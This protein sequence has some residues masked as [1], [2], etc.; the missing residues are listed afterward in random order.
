MSLLLIILTVLTAHMRRLNL[1]EEMKPVT[2]TLKEFHDPVTVA[3]VKE[4][5]MPL[6]P[7]RCLIID[8]KHILLLADDH[9]IHHSMDV[10]LDYM[11]V[12]FLI[13]LAERELRPHIK[14]HLGE[15]EVELPTLII[16]Y[17]EQSSIQR[18]KIDFGPASAD[19][20]H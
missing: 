1:I 6:A 9:R 17:A 4:P 20:E 16:K 19:V 7:V 15:V 18:H 11:P 14:P 2:R 12:H 8:E 13:V 3:A 10:L 5:V